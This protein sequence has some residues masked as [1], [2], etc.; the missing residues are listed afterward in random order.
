MLNPR[1]GILDDILSVGKKVGDYSGLGSNGSES[2]RKMAFVKSMNY[3]TVVP[4]NRF[5]GT[6]HSA[7]TTKLSSVPT[8]LQL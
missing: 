2:S 6:S 1:S 8:Y 3:P 5:A 4:T 7:E